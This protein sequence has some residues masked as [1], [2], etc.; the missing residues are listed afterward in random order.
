MA[1]MDELSCPSCGAPTSL[2]QRFC[3]ACGASV[4]RTCPSC[5][6]RWAPS[7][8][9]CGSCGTPF[10]FPSDREPSPAAGVTPEERK[11]VTVVF[12]D[13]SGSTEIATRLDPEDL[14]GVL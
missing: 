3:G 11:F 9:F 2:D 6:A 4:E 7:F 13:L 1:P 10:G 12:A 14:R 8:R 5:G